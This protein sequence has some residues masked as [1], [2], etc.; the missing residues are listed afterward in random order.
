MNKFKR[1]RTKLGLSQDQIARK[2]GVSVSSVVGW[3]REPT[4]AILAKMEKLLGDK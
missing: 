4:D 3:E 1:L 2:L